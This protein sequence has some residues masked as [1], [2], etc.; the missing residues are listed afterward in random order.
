MGAE[1]WA[2]LVYLCTNAD[3][4]TV[5]DVLKAKTTYEGKMPLN[6]PFHTN[7]SVIKNP[8]LFSFRQHKF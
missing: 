8:P 6:C 4:C 7:T 3:F 5:K 1:W 2:L